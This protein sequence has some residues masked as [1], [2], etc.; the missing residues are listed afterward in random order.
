MTKQTP[1]IQNIPL[2][3]EPVNKLLQQ[4][5]IP[6]IIAMLVSALYNIVDQIFV[7]RGNDFSH[8]W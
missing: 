4:F 6:S 5:A 2:G 7:G 1:K 8:Y 3:T